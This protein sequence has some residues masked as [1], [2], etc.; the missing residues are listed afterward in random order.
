VNCDDCKA[1]VLELIEREAVDPTGVRAVLAE[2][3]DCRAEFDEVKA[4]LA[5]AGELPLEEPP[6]ALDAE[7]L[8]AAE[9]RNGAA[10]A[11]ERTPWRQPLAMAAVAMLAVGIGVSTISI[12]NRPQDEDAPA[13]RLEESAAELEAPASQT[14]AAGGVA[15]DDASPEVGNELAAAPPAEEVEEAV[16]RQAPRPVARRSARKKEAKDAAPEPHAEVAQADLAEAQLGA[17]DA[18]AAR[19][20]AAASGATIQKSDAVEAVEDDAEA[21]ATRRCARTVQALEKRRRKDAEHEPTPEAALEAGL[22]YRRLGKND[23]ARHW[24]RR[25]AEHSSTKARANEALEELE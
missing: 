9:A 21:S 12:G 4:L 19:A 18:P 13:S 16:A 23:E 25:A 2:C 3:P 1:Q 22:C 7:I 10:A 8:Q 5:L 15:M 14:K 24:L 20:G 11:P 17:A 6:A